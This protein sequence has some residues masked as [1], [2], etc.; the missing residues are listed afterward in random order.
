[1]AIL[2]ITKSH[3]SGGSKI[4]QKVADMSGY[5][6]ISLKKILDDT[7]HAGGIWE[8]FVSE[9]AEDYPTIWDRHDWSFMGFMALLQSVILNYAEQD[10][11]VIMARGACALLKD[12]PH[13]LRVRITAPV[14]FRTQEVVRKEALP[15][16][17]AR[18]IIQEADRAMQGA[19]SRLYGEDWNAQ[20]NFELKF[21]TSRIP[22]A[23]I[24][25]EI[26]NALNGKEK[27]NT[28]EAKRQLH[29]RT[30]AAQVKAVIATNPQ[31]LIPTLEVTVE[32]KMIKI[33]GVVR[34]LEEQ[35][36][37]EKQARIMA[38]PERIT[39]DFQYRG[40]W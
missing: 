15:L 17:T 10:N 39:T 35:E 31:F 20:E 27:L 33:G 2:A 22:K 3:G 36:E 38:L 12:I 9:Y 28:V 13:A 23:D 1:M 40:S 4:G 8:R 34:S 21:D 19:M 29:L 16:K 32:G 30:V 11:K 26:R 6:F 37:I 7:K 5:E 25:E 24:V 14:E 18:L